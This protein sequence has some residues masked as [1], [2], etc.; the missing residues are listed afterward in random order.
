MTKISWGVRDQGGA[1][2]ASANPRLSTRRAQTRRPPLRSG[3][4]D[5]AG[6]EAWRAPGDVDNGASVSLASDVQGKPAGMW[7]SHAWRRARVGGEEVVVGRRSSRAPA[8]F[9][10]RVA[11]R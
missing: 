2:P 1:Q 3:R 11:D 5:E 10:D 8:P 9:R 7:L 4:D 6:L